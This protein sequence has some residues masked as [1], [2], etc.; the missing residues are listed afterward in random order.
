MRA[1]RAH[2][3]MPSAGV[4]VKLLCSSYLKDSRTPHTG[5]DARAYMFS[6]W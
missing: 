6:N 4:E 3:I 1:G 2:G 5:A